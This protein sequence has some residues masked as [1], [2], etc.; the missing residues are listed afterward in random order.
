LLV[1]TG[2]TAMTM[3]EIARCSGA[4]LPA[5]YRRW[6]SKAEL[7]QHVVRSGFERRGIDPDGD[8]FEELARYVEGVV[9]VLCDEVTAAALPGLLVDLHGD[10]AMRERYYGIF[11]DDRAP[12]NDLVTRAVAEGIVPADTTA[13][14]INLVIVGMAL[15]WALNRPGEAAAHL[16]QLIF[17]FVC[18]V[19]RPTSDTTA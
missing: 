10:R 3:Q 5:I 1:E 14:Q 16:Q 8:F 12:F 19:I 18:R 2:Y 4:S 9:T 13:D 11:R 17:D 7:V 15:G 6:P